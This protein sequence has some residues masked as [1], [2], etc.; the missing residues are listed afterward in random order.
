[1]D[2][3]FFSLTF[4]LAMGW[5]QAHTTLE[6]GLLNRIAKDLQDEENQ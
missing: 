3:G 5:G 1:M 2:V 4:I 6:R